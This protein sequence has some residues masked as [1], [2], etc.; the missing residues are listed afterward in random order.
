MSVSNIGDLFLF[1]D[2]SFETE[3]ATASRIMVYHVKELTIKFAPCG[4]SH[5]RHVKGEPIV[6]GLVEAV[7]GG[8]IWG[9]GFALAMGAVQS[10]AGGAR[11]VAKDAMKGALGV[12][13][14]FRSATATGREA[15]RGAYDEAKA[16][17]ETSA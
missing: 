1:R 4:A 9:A 17:R 8:A 2:R 11:P 7:T 16:E 14:W 6:E 15:M 5:S 10:L 13:D 12:V 3:Y